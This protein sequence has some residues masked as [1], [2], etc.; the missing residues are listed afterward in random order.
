MALNGH[1][2]ARSSCGIETKMLSW[3]KQLQ[4]VAPLGQE[5]TGRHHRGRWFGFGFGADVLPIVWADGLPSIGTYR[6]ILSDHIPQCG[7][8]RRDIDSRIS[9]KAFSRM[10]WWV[11]RDLRSLRLVHH[12]WIWQGYDHQTSSALAA[13]WSQTSLRLWCCIVQPPDVGWI[14]WC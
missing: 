12:W 3:T 4:R 10:H 13:R 8:M 5:S 7:V 1:S 11:G 9:T 14:H 6:T 2:A